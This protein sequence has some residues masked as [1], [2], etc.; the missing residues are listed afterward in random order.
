MTY[1]ELS[2]YGHLRKDGKMGTIFYHIYRNRKLTAYRAF[3]DVPKTCQRLEWQAHSRRDSRVSLNHPE[4][5]L[6]VYSDT[7][8]LTSLTVK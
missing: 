1:E 2:L 6:P 5:T 7:D 4:F 8:K 3:R